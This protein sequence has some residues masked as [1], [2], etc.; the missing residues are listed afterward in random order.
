MPPRKDPDASANVPSFYGAELR[1]KRELAGLTLEQLAEGSFRGVPF[2]SQIERGERRMPI[3]LARHVDQVLGTDGF[4]ERRCE[5]ARRARQSGHAEYFADVA[6][7]EQHA[8]SIEEWAPSLVPGLLQTK[9]YATAVVRTSLPWLRPE[10]VEKQV[11]ARMERAKL[12]QREDQPAFWAILHEALIDRP[13]LPP[14]QAAAQL[15]HIAHVIRS[16]QSVLQIVPETTAAHPMMMGMIKVMTFTDQPPVVYTEGL[17][18]GQLIDYPA[19]VKDY[20]RSYDLL[21]A[22][23]LSPEASLAMI[24]QAAKDFRNGRHRA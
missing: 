10:T 22:T 20:R 6:E 21:R 7:M 13:L 9:A 15:E 17:H 24:D 16:T 8:E 14:E 11:R 2:L 19:L 23:A 3:D 1:Y 12:W 18:S 4:F 5:D